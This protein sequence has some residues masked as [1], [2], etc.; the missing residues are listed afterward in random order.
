MPLNL[1]IRH[2]AFLK[3]EALNKAPSPFLHVNCAGWVPLPLTI[4]AVRLVPR[5]EIRVLIFCLVAVALIYLVSSAVTLRLL[6]R[7]SLGLTTSIR[8]PASVAGF[9]VPL[10]LGFQLGAWT[11]S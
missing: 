9:A 7:L 3:S 10:I 5:G 11:C 6:L 8:N 1:V 4:L 2:R